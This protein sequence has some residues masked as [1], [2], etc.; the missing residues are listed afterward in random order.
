MSDNERPPELLPLRPMAAR[1]GVP[2]DWLQEQAEAGNI[3]GLK[4]G[5]RWLFAPDVVRD[6]V[7]AM[8]GD[9]LAGLLSPEPKKTGGQS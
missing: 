8:A 3:P 9:P 7:R 4:A 6:A 2:S 1:V 5:K